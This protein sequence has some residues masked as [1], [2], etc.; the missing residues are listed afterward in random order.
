MVFHR[1]SNQR[2]FAQTSAPNAVRLYPIRLEILLTIGCQLDDWRE[3]INWR[4]WRICMWASW[5]SI[6]SNGT[7]YETMPRF[8]TFLQLLHAGNVT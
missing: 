3:T 8:A 2:D 5:D 4:S 1:L 6:N 7:Q